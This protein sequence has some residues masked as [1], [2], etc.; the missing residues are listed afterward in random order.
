MGIRWFGWCFEVLVGFIRVW[1]CFGLLWI[2]VLG[3]GLLF[4]LGLTILA[5][6]VVL[7]VDS[8]T[9]GWW[10]LAGLI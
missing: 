10:F 1:R 6:G 3:L 4:Y 2:W 7:W 5:A 8:G 9:C